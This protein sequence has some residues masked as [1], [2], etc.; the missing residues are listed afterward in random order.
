MPLSLGYSANNFR[1]VGFVTIKHQDRVAS[2]PSRSMFP[3]LLCIFCLSSFISLFVY[4]RFLS[5]VALSFVCLSYPVSP[6]SSSSSFSSS[7]SSSL[8]LL[9]LLLLLGLLFFLLSFY[10]YFCLSGSFLSLFLRVFSVCLFLSFFLPLFISSPPFLFLF[11]LFVCP[12]SSSSS[13]SI[14]LI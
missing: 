11:F 1:F 6:S 13:S 14:A 5:Y 7:F 4:V 12:L 9:L 2:W 8:V 10:P 3:A